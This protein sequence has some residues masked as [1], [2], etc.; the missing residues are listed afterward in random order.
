MGIKGWTP[1]WALW[2]PVG[3]TVPDSDPCPCLSC[4][5]EGRNRP[6]TSL[7]L[8]P[9]GP[10]RP[11]APGNPVAPYMRR[12]EV[13]NPSGPQ[14]AQESDWVGGSQRLVWK[15]ELERALWGLAIG[16]GSCSFSASSPYRGHRPGHSVP[17]GA[18]R[19]LRGTTDLPGPRHTR[20]E[21]PSFPRGCGL[22]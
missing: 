16:S 10:T 21:G 8:E 5:E 19:G 22:D 3:G 6:G 12:R 13:L 20:R 4:Q 15:G 18:E 1:V 2:V 7:T 11:A 17:L 9:G 14:E